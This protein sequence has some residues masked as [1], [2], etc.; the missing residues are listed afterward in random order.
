MKERVVSHRTLPDFGKRQP[1]CFVDLHC[2]YHI[3]NRS[4]HKVIKSHLR[5]Y[6]FSAKYCPGAEWS[7]QSPLPS[8]RRQPRFLT[9]FSRSV[10]SLDIAPSKSLMQ[11]KLPSS[12]EDNTTIVSFRSRPDLSRRSSCQDNVYL[13]QPFH[14]LQSKRVSDQESKPASNQSTGRIDASSPSHGSCLIQ[15]RGL[16]SKA[17]HVPSFRRKAE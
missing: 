11:I 7:N 2:C 9:K 8:N 4:L 10:A 6:Q 17:S 13:R 12:S 1:V 5:K 14:D 16:N 15:F 3:E